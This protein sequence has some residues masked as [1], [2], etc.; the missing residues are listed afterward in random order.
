MAATFEGLSPAVPTQIFFSELYDRFT[1]PAAWHIF[2]DVVPA[3]DFLERRGLKL[4]IISNWDDRLRPLLRGLRLYERFD[5]IVIS[6]EAG[7][8]KPAAAIF[9]RAARELGLP[10]GSM[11]HVGDSLEDDV[12][13]ALAAGCRALLLHR[14]AS[15]PGAIRSL[16]ELGNEE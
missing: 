15:V 2:P 16:A 14:E 3:L 5:S 4:G 8:T 6:C 1:E 11:L 7:V 9:A 10:L 12:R 13:G